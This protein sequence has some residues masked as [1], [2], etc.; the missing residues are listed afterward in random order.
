MTCVKHF[1]LTPTK[2]RAGQQ[3]DK[4]IPRVLDAAGGGGA[5]EVPLGAPL[6]DPHPLEDPGE[7]QLDG[8]AEEGEVGLGQVGHG[9]DR[10]EA[11]ELAELSASESVTSLTEL[12]SAEDEL[13][14]VLSSTS[15]ESELLEVSAALESSAAL[16]VSAALEVSATLDISATLE[17]SAAP[18]SPV[19]LSS[20]FSHSGIAALY[21]VKT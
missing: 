17:L 19:V 9:R 3:V 6:I 5:L 2:N 15:R 10:V 16:D 13:S 14:D 8:R 20:L 1:S 11:A 21:A 12:E 4:K 7:H 18:E